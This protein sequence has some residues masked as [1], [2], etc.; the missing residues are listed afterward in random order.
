LAGL[1]EEMGDPER[2]V[3]SYSSSTARSTSPTV[4]TMAAWR[5]ASSPEKCGATSRIA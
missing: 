5:S 2:F 1:A 3:M 4:A